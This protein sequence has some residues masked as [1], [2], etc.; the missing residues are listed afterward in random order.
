MTTTTTREDE[1]KETTPKCPLLSPRGTKHN[2]HSRADSLKHINE[3]IDK[4]GDEDSDAEKLSPL[5]QKNIEVSNNNGVLPI[6]MVDVVEP[7]DDTDTDENSK[8]DKSGK[9]YSRFLFRFFYINKCE[10]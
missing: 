7:I 10:H 5:L 6:K 2:L 3:K 8:L 4:D 1:G 9:N